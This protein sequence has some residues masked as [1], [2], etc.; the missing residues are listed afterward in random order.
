[1]FSKIGLEN[2]KCFGAYTEF[3]LSR[4]NIF[5]GYNGRGKSSVFQA[6]LLLA[7]SIVN[8]KDINILN[9]NGC[10]VS[11]DLFN[12]IVN[13]KNKGNLIKFCFEGRGEYSNESHKVELSYGRNKEN[14][15]VGNLNNL[16]LDGTNYYQDTKTL[17]GDDNAKAKQVKSYPVLTITNLFEHISYISADRLGPTKYEEEAELSE[18][19]PIGTHG[20]KR[21]NVLIKDNALLE[22]TANDISNIMDCEAINLTDSKSNA[23]RIGIL[24]WQWQQKDKGNKHGFRL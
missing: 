15:R 10:F 1:M 11:L 8:N 2:F 22:K 17:G 20:E 16:M 12:D 21:L 19:N 18:V 3:S 24:F 9:V 7:Q 14:D 5:T 13:F 4:M 23:A 6:L